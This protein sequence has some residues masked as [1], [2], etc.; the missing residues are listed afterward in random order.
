MVSPIAQL[1]KSYFNVFGKHEKTQNLEMTLLFFIDIITVH[2]TRCVNKYAKMKC[3]MMQQWKN[4]KNK[5][6]S[7]FGQ[8][9]T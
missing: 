5:Q 2:S 1:P 3:R 4:S 9:M 7:K 6:I 8:I